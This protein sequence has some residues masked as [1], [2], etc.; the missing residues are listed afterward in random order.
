MHTALRVL[1]TEHSSVKQKNSPHF[2][3][4]KGAL[5]LILVW[6]DTFSL[7][8]FNPPIMEISLPSWQKTS[9]MTQLKT[10]VSQMPRFSFARR[11]LSPDPRAIIPSAL[12]CS[13]STTC[14][15]PGQ[16]LFPSYATSSPSNHKGRGSVVVIFWLPQPQPG[17]GLSGRWPGNIYWKSRHRFFLMRA[18]APLHS[19]P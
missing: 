18:S 1:V 8:F 17:T 3:L 16:W 14:A 6:K 11:K 4:V 7:Y 10:Q 2:L 9:I 19:S 5:V 13:I 15:Y 12:S